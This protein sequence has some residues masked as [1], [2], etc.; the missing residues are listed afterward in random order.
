MSLITFPAAAIHKVARTKRLKPKSFS[1][2]LSSQGVQ[3]PTKTGVLAM[4]VD[5]TSRILYNA[6][7]AAANESKA[8]D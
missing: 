2:N 1:V 5:N 6:Q 4:L 3:D 7:Y 8:F